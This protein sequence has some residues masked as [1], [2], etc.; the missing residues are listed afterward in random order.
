MPLFVYKK[1]TDKVWFFIGFQTTTTTHNN[2]NQH[3]GS[4][5]LLPNAASLLTPS[6]RQSLPTPLQRRL[7]CPTSRRGWASRQAV[8]LSAVIEGP[9][10]S[11][12]NF[13]TDHLRRPLPPTTLCPAQSTPVLPPQEQILPKMTRSGAADQHHCP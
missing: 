5:H 8:G 10:L 9:L 4:V 11:F 7:H 1:K 2:N 6:P 3:S 13:T 12:R